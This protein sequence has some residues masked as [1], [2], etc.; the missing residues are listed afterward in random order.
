MYY[1]NLLLYKGTKAQ[2]MKYHRIVLH[3]YTIYYY[4]MINICIILIVHILN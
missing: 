1:K 4:Y 3:I 2:M